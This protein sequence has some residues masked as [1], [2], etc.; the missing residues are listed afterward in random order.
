MASEKKMAANRRNAARSTGPRTPPGT[1]RSSLNAL[2][3]GLTA[4]TVVTAFEDEQDYEAF[5][6]T[7]VAGFDPRSIVERQLVLRLSSLLWRLRRAVA[8]FG[9]KPL[10]LSLCSA[11]CEIISKWPVN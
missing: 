9:V 10:K 8:L 6:K 3:H 5:E 11:S 7:L 1:R 4:V 2:R